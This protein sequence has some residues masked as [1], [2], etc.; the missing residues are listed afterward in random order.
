[1]FISFTCFVIYLI[2][3]SS[4]NH[5]QISIEAITASKIDISSSSSSTNYT[6]LFAHNLTINFIVENLDPREI[7]YKSV[8]GRGHKKL[9]K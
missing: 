9:F 4:T 1:M 8:V 7:E 6:S 5:T 2:N 3:C